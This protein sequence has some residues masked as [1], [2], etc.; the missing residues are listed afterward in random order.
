MKLMMPKS[1]PNSA[2]SDNNVGE[3]KVVMRDWTVEDGSVSRPISPCILREGM[4]APFDFR[5]EQD[6]SAV[7][8]LADDI[9]PLSPMYTTVTAA[10]ATTT[11]PI[12]RWT[13]DEI[14]LALSPPGLPMKM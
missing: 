5:L 1:Q 14:G 2:Q 11:T 12:W 10:A 6:D 8:V 9:S 13:A 7:A 3:E 4:E